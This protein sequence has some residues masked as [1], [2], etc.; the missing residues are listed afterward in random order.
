[1]KVEGN[2]KTDIGMVRKTNQDSYYVNNKSGFYI[3]ADG[4]GGHAGGEVA[5]GMV[6]AEFEEKL[7]EEKGVE[8]KEDADFHIFLERTLNTACTKIYE[9]SL[10]NPE[11]KGM[12]TTASC[13]FIKDKKIHCGHV[14]DSRIYLIRAGFIYQLSVDHSLVSEQLKAGLITEEM[15]TNHQLKNVITRSI[16]YQEEEFVDTF[17]REVERGDIILLCSDGLHGKVSDQEIVDICTKNVEASADQLVN[18][19][20]ERGGEDNISVIVVTID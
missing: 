14:G 6:V 15:A 18:L 17:S 5:S 2:G 1:M 20:N 12:G 16:G 8:L 19:A 10:E 3:V 4:M 9:K 11:L 7:T 13:A